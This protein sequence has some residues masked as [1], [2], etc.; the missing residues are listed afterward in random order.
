MSHPAIMLFIQH[1]PDIAPGEGVLIAHLDH[2]DSDA[3]QFNLIVNPQ[4]PD[5]ELYARVIL[6]ASQLIERYAEVGDMIISVALSSESGVAERLHGFIYETLS[7]RL[8]LQGRTPQEAT[9]VTI[10][11]GAGLRK[12]SVPSIASGSE[13]FADVA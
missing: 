2:I 3:G 4:G 10:V 8:G 6:P 9:V 1:R 12:C 7:E 5:K 11:F 13:Y